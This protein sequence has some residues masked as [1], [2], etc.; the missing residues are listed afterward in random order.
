M[1]YFVGAGTGAVDLITVRG[2]RLLE[3]ADVII[4]AGSLVNPEL[5][6]YAKREC[7][8]YNSAEMTLEEVIHILCIAEEKGKTTVR[9]HTGDPSIYGAVREQMD[10]LDRLGISYESCPGVS[11]CF[12]ASS[13][14]NL[15]Y[16]LP[17]ISQSLIITRMEGRTKVPER[18]SIERFAA[19]RAS[20]AIYLSAGMIE[21]LSKRL[22]EGGYEKTTPAALVYKAT[23]DEEEAYVCTIE[24]LFDTS[25]K[26]GI[27]STALVLVGDV[28][29]HRHY[30]RSRLYA[31]DFSTAFREKK[32]GISQ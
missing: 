23:W 19:H 27:T 1:V 5:L 24:T 31:P 16:T 15:E 10:E 20:M 26:H 21:E 18:E 17:G 6:R 14:L 2:A 22:L 29:A 25:V 8:I 11:A 3:Q 4:Y 28:I 7:E 30:E 12:G 13:S 9:L 32:E